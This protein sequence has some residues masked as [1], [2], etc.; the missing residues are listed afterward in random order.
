MGFYIGVDVGTGS[1]RAGVFDDAG[2]QRGVAVQAIRTWQPAA[3]H[4]EQSSDDIWQ[5]V[6]N[7][8]RQAMDAAG[9]AG[10]DVKGVG[11]DATCSLVVLDAQGRPVTVSPS[12]VD[13]QNVVLWMDH[14]AAAI[15]DEIN[16]AGHDVLRYVG[17]RVSPE[18][19]SPKLVWLKRNLA[20]SWQRAAHFF[21]LPDFLT[22]RATG[23]TTR[24]L[25]S[26]V[27]KWTYLGHE[28]QG[29][30]A[31][32]FEAIGL[33]DLVEEGF[34]RIG[35]DICPMGEAVGSGLSQQ[36]AE[37]M[38]LAA[39]T[40]VSVSI[41]DAHAG[42]IGMIGAGVGEA[43]GED[44]YNRRLALIGGTSSCHMAVSRQPR[45]IDGVWG[46]YYS[47]MLPGY[48]LTEGGQSAT[49]SLVDLIVF[50]HGASAALV[51]QA[52]NEG[53]S[54]YESLNDRLEELAGD[55]AMAELTASLHVCPYF[56]GNRSP[57]ANPHLRGM[58]SGL[59][60]S[61]TLDD[62]AR[63]YLATIQAIA[64][65]TRHIIEALNGSGYAVDTI[66]ACGGGTRNP[67]FLQQHADITGCRI[68]LP[69]EGE[70]VLLGSAMLG[71]AAAGRF[72]SLDD[73][74]VAMSSVGSVVQPDPAVAAYHDR[75]Y[76]VFD[77]LHDDQLDYAQ[78]MSKGGGRGRRG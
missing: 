37:E 68:I 51:E 44:A 38:Q 15:A 67:V 24:S 49:G 22:W 73:A 19:E 14:R 31:G 54:A 45:F 34:E 70:S 47:A 9:L 29:W 63:L 27:C 5:A 75:K 56:H 28:E 25:C 30:D 77:Q 66:V 1:V 10:P 17:G 52:E 26:T 32:Y 69:G 61:A 39:G 58:I 53:R 4:Y 16:A 43:D 6:C 72:D 42:G 21:D 71:A 35:T 55:G 8:V 64:Y 48:W 20:A 46:P 2:R 11:F 18:M 76:K 7:C 60:L 36:A 13:E 50:E 59:S 41:I 33:G 12:G 40:P 57:R 65:G 78:V 23:S 74:M 62:L 3:E